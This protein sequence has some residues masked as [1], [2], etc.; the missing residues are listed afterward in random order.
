M[1]FQKK[2][3]STE[4]NNE[5]ENSLEVL[6]IA[7]DAKNDINESQIELG[8]LFLLLLCAAVGF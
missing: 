7:N 4:E 1:I 8:F 6:E 5:I 3:L 2:Q